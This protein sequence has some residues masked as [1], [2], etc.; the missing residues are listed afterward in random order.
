LAQLRQQDT[1]AYDRLMAETTAKRE[2]LA[3]QGIE[4]EIYGQPQPSI[5]LLILKILGLLLTSP[6]AF[7]GWLNSVI[8]YSIPFIFTKKLKDQQFSSAFR[9]VFFA[10]VTFPFIWLIQIGIVRGVTD[11]KTAILY[12]LSLP[13]TGYFAHR[14]ARW[15][16]ATVQQWKLR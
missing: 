15:W 10:L 8:P 4:A 9:I 12:A 11:A 5:S 6:I 16:S 2:D 14:W 7:Y 3:K 13:P 1:T